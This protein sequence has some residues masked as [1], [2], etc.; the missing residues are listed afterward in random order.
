MIDFKSF[1][2]PGGGT[3]RIRTE[4]II[5][6]ISSKGSDNVD[7][8]CSDT[9]VPFHIKATK[10]TP[11]ELVDYIWNIPSFENEDDM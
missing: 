11:Q 9:A 8:Y 1:A 6:T 10:K 5:A 7:I 4:K 2:L 3:L